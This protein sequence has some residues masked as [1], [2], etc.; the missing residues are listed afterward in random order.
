[1]EDED[2]EDEDEGHHIGEDPHQIV[3]IWS[4]REKDR[5]PLSLGVLLSP[6]QIILDL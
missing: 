2:D 6:I 1:M 3:L 4:L 5:Q